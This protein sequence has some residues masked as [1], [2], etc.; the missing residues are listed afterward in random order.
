MNVV[1]PDVT[2]FFHQP[3]GSVSY[4]LADPAT[5]R[6]AVIDAVLD[7]DQAAGRTSTAFADAICAHVEKA[8]LAI[9]WVLETHAHADHLSAAQHVKRRLGGRLAIGEHIRDVQQ[10]F[11]RLYNIACPGTD[12]FD[13]LFK[14][15]ERFKIGALDADVMHTPGHTPACLSYHVGD[16]VFCGDTLFMPDYGTARCDFPGGSAETLYRSIR[17]LLA[18]PAETRIF[19][20]HDYQPGGRPAAWA[21]TVGQ[22]RAANK[23]VRDGVSEAD[24]ARMR[25]ERDATLG[26]PQLLW[27]SVLVNI[28][29]GRLPRAEGNGLSYLKLPLNA[30]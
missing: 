20:G 30:L 14:D 6:G 16:A 8:G 4:V 9:D 24:F 21:S 18:L 12:G 22:Q 1:R 26:M 19:C 27:P 5:R 11:A 17:R 29:A 15:G 23:H 28:D 7:F 3:T 2:G 13:H 25:R 10:C